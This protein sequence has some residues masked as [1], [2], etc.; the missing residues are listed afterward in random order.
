MPG[1]HEPY[2]A[3]LK[4]VRD[5]L[6]LEQ[7]VAQTLLSALPL[8]EQ[9]GVSALRSQDLLEPLM[10]CYRSLHATGNGLIADGHLLDVIRRVH[11]F[12]V[13]LVRLDVRQDSARHTALLDAITRGQYAAWNEEQRQEFLL[14]SLASRD[15]LLPPE[16]ELDADAAEDLQ[17]F[18]AIAVIPRESLGAYVI[19]MAHAASDVLAVVLLQREAGVR[20]PLR[21]VPLFETRADLRGAAQ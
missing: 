1:V 11:A 5:R 7:H 14:R 13:T 17:T 15:P 10:R 16:L 3:V 18:R 19:T 9:T 6:R 12:G 8:S 20:D 4:E 21:V 2:R